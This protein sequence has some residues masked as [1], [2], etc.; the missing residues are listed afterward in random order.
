MP[1]CTSLSIPGTLSRSVDGGLKKERKVTNKMMAI[2][3]GYRK[4]K[5]F[6][7]KLFIILVQ[8]YE[9]LCIFALKIQEIGTD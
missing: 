7:S 6:M 4:I 5:P 9:L 3:S 2:E 1:V 8:K